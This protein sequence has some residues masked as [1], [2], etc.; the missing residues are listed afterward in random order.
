[1]TSGT[2][3]YSKP[4]R[5]SSFFILDKNFKQLFSVQLQFVAV[6]GQ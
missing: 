1:M 3:C 2:P 6:T 4:L 5:I